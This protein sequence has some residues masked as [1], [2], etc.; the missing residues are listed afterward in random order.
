MAYWLVIVQM[1]ASWYYLKRLAWNKGNPGLIPTLPFNRYMGNLSI[2][3]AQIK[4]K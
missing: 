4:W 2:L 1:R 3:K